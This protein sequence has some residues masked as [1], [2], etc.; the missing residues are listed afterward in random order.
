MMVEYNYNY[1]KATVV[2][3]TDDLILV[4]TT[5]GEVWM[6]DPLTQAQFCSFSEKGREFGNGNPVTAI[7]AHPAKSDYILVGYKGG[8]VIL[9]DVTEQTPDHSK[10]IKVI[11]DHHKGSP[12]TNLQ[13]CD[14]IS[15]NHFQQVQ[16]AQQPNQ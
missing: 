11:K 12:I 4:G 13:F 10:A 15:G 8:Q 14:V 3:L 9:L 16:R 5:S 1:S 6:Y 2:T 7:A